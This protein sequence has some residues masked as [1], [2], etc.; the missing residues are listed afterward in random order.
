MVR[1]EAGSRGR[2][3]VGR[4]GWLIVTILVVAVLAAWAQDEK[5]GEDSAA[6]LLEIDATP[7]VE[8]PIEPDVRPLFSLGY[9]GDIVAHLPLENIALVSPA[10][11]L[12][13]SYMPVRAGTSISVIRFGVGPR[14]SVDLGYR[15]RVFGHALGGGY[16]SLFNR[17]ARDAEGNQ[18]A[19]QAGVAGYVGGGIG[20]SF[21]LTPF[22]SAGMSGSYG[23][24]LGLYQSASAS[25]SLTLHVDGFER[26]I[27]IDP[28]DIEPIYPVLVQYYG[29]AS[30]GSATVTN[31][32]RFP[33]QNVEIEVTVP[34]LTAQAVALPVADEI[35]PGESVRTAVPTLFSQEVLK[36][37]EAQRT[38]AG[39][40]VRYRLNGRTRE[41]T[42]H[43]ALRLYN[44]NA[45][46]FVMPRDAELQRFASSVAGLVRSEGPAAM[47]LNLRIAM[48]LY[49][50]LAIHGLGYVVDPDTPAYIEASTD[51]TV[52][53]FLQF[54]GQ[55]LSFHGG[56][57]D[58]LSILYTSLL[59]AVG[60]PTAFLTIP[61][62]LFM[63]FDTGLSVEEAAR[64]FG[65]ASLV[66]D[67]GGSA[68]IPV[69]MT[70]IG[71]TFRESWRIAADQWRTRS[72]EGIDVEGGE[73]GV[74]FY[75]MRESWEVYPPSGSPPDIGESVA[76]DRQTI[77]LSYRDA[78]DNLVDLQL[79]PQIARLEEQIRRSG[80]PVRYQNR[81][82]A[83]YA[84]YGL[85]DR[86][87]EVLEEV[88]RQENYP[89]AL[90]N[91][92]NIRFLNGRYEEARDLYA[93]AAQEMLDNPAVLVGLAK[94]SYELGDVAGLRTTYN[95]LQRVDP[96]VSD[97]FGSLS[98][99]AE[100]PADGSARADSLDAARVRVLWED[101]I[102]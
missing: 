70:A 63:A 8:I 71:R 93:R 100:K 74:G 99:I 37:L 90:I 25:L 21:F 19:D 96:E 29:D 45:A 24:Q 95:R 80:N 26:K 16:V 9:G 61:G 73:S 69:E 94:V 48:G 7:R 78:V 10:L 82:G 50:A 66:I 43:V 57:C 39:I 42:R 55:T 62:H 84:R 27:R 98:N 92:A 49:E 53:D 31:G 76:M 81:L 3:S 75:P 68:W 11:S 72:R 18:Y 102:Q 46:A 41:S 88:A 101:E 44:R 77:R 51:T 97:Q 52:V 35:L 14:L 40:T 85:L 22:L 47:N 56:D 32:E 28:V 12:S 79:A 91:L 34:G 17:T 86:A 67:R 15:F 30:V 87:V 6:S 38:S 59:E 33:I 54:P 83:L 20:A 60:I 23:N 58:D 5:A 13:Y 64:T 65:D 1:T 2:C 89:P 4:R 36:V